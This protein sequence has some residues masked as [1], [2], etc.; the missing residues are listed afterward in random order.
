MSCIFYWLIE[1]IL[2][3]VRYLHYIR[4]N[5]IDKKSSLLRYTRWISRFDQ[6]TIL[7]YPLGFQIIFA[8]DAEVISSIIYIFFLLTFYTSPRDFIEPNYLYWPNLFQ[9]KSNGRIKT[10]DSV[11][12][13]DKRIKLI[14]R[15]FILG[16]NVTFHMKQ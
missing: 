13:I 4:Y 15:S 9:G 5:T 3:I 7:R 12:F 10:H 16:R 2:L 1:D 6:K 14:I 11:I 8:T